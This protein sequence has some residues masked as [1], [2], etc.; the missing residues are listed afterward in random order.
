MSPT[1]GLKYAKLF[2][3]AKICALKQIDVAE[4]ENRCHENIFL[5]AA[6]LEQPN[7][8]FETAFVKLQLIVS[9]SCTKGYP[10]TV[11]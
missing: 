11:T 8:I 7:K 10:G 4:L 1:S 3:L 2:I 9:S 6:S 5:S